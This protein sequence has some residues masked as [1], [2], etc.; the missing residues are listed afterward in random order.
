MQVVEQCTFNRRKV[1]TSWPLLVETPDRR[2]LGEA[3]L[4]CFELETLVKVR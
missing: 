4:G 2:A 3:E 1:Y